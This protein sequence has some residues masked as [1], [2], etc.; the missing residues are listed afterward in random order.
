MIEGQVALVEMTGMV[1]VF[2]RMAVVVVRSVG[3]NGERG[4]VIH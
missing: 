4:R 2:V 3:V 1:K